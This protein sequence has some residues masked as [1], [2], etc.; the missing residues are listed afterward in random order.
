[1][2]NCFL[3][4]PEGESAC[5]V[6]AYLQ[7]G[8]KTAEMEERLCPAVVIC[9]G[10]G[11]TFLAEREAGP[12]GK[13]YFAAGYQVF[14]VEYS[15]NEA[16]AGFRPLCQ[17]AAVVAHIRKQAGMW[18]IAADKIAVCGFSAGGHLAASLGTLYND[19]TFLAV[20]KRQEE[21]RPNALIL[22]Y[23]VIL[24]NEYAHVRSIETVSK[25]AAGTV[26][27]EWF[28]LDRHVTPLTPPVF[29]WHTAADTCVPVENS[30]AFAAALSRAKVPF[31]LH[32]LPKGEH[33]MSVCTREVGSYDPYNARW[34]GWSVEWLGRQFGFEK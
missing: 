33:G 11:Y 4:H 30:L 25:A 24:A 8:G 32:I 22:G 19:E 14:V 29:L 9:P 20:W 27:Y 6:R 18:Q 28:G 1:M 7:T 26:E 16:A 34:I 31:E 3:F 10:G 13:E 15:V 21:I 17:L 5:T 2:V 12:V 23:P